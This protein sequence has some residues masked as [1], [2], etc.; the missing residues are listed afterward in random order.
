MNREK[1]ESLARLIKPAT[2]AFGQQLPAQTLKE[3]QNRS[4]SCDLFISIGSSLVVYP[5]AY[6]P[7]TAKEAGATLVIVNREPTP[8]D[9][10]ADLIIHGQA[11]EI[12]QSAVKLS[13]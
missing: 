8:L 3:A 1:I 7:Q 4:L 13:R 2:I 6:L 5:A 12:M 9:P 11:G 10:L